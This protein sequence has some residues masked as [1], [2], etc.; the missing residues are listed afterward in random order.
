MR[1]LAVLLQ[2]RLVPVGAELA[3]AAG[4]GDDIDPAPLQPQLADRGRIAGQQRRLEAA[5]AVVART[6]KALEEIDAVLAD[7]AIYVKDPRKAADLGQKRLK[8]QAAVDKAEA[9]WMDIAEQ[10]AALETA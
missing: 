6:T 10:L 4:I 7:P 1:P 8:A 9:E 5:E 3:A 2:G